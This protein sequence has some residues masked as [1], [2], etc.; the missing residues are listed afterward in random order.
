MAK[1]NKTKQTAKK[2][3]TGKAN[4]VK[5]PAAAAQAGM[6]TTDIRKDFRKTLLGRFTTA[7]AGSPGKRA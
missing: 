5:K 2:K 4:S 6:M 3:T 7:K 1:S